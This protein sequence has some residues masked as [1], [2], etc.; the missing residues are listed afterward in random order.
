MCSSSWTC[1]FTSFKFC[2]TSPSSAVSCSGQSNL[3]IPHGA[4]QCPPA[5]GGGG[6]ASDPTQFSPKPPHLPRW[7]PR[8]LRKTHFSVHT[9]LSDSSFLF[10]VRF[11]SLATEGPLCIS[12][13][14]SPH[15]SRSTAYGKLNKA[16]FVLFLCLF[17]LPQ[18]GLLQCG[19][20]I[21]SYLNLPGLVKRLAT[22]VYSTELKQTDSEMNEP[23]NKNQEQ[24]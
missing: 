11:L 15:R 13:T 6:P 9:I 8:G 14:P 19:G 7:S 24:R 1:L 18:A 3:Q 17:S 16:I 22:R 10:V 5:P 23:A 2:P 12:K 21:C 4:R 20:H